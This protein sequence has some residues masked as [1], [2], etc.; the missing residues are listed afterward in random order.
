MKTRLGLTWVCLA[1]IASAQVATAQQMMQP[2]GGPVSE[3]GNFQ[4]VRG[5]LNVGMPGRLWFESNIADRGLG[6]N[7]S[8]LTLGG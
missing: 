1:L 5:D 7:G 6:Y 2:Y 3:Q 8:Y 4:P